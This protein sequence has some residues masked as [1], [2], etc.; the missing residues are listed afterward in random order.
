MLRI[1]IVDD[2][3]IVRDGL[4]LLIEK[5]PD[6]IIVDEAIS[7]EEALQK[8]GAG[9]FDAVVLDITLPGMSGIKCSYRGSLYQKS[10]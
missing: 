6:M 7:G 9:E 8:I 1:L 4:R 2:H 3:P 5:I 10:F